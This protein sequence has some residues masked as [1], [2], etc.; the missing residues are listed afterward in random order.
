MTD[1]NDVRG[2]SEAE[3]AAE[4]GVALPD[5]EVVSILDLNADLDLAIDAAA[6]IDLGVAANAN[7]AAP[8]DASVGANVLSAGSTAQALSDQGALINQ[9][10]HAD[11]TA[12]A[13]QDSSLEQGAAPDGTDTTADGTTAGGT[14]DGTTADAGTSLPTDGSTADPGAAVGGAG[15]TAGSLADGNLL[16]VDVNLD[17]DA[18]IAA[19]IN[20]AVAANAN[21]AAPIDASVAAN[22][23]SIDSDAVSV[24]QQDAVI[25]QDID[26]SA[27]A[28]S[29]QTSDITQ[30]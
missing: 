21:V 14:T 29:D 6:P 8:I 11:A 4:E 25:N 28:S 16:N 2:L 30:P 20:G 13:A 24:A 19:P 1:H 27:T 17:G 23:G 22:V 26:G 18:N 9:G 7:V 12:N 10:I 3:L 15:S 5:K